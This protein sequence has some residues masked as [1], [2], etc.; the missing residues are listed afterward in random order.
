MKKSDSILI[1]ATIGLLAYV[2]FLSLLGPA[3]S[4]AQ[5]SKTIGNAG[6]VTAV[7]V[8]VYW[9]SDGTNPVSSFSWGMIDPGTNESITCYI[10]NEGNSAVTLSMSTSSWNPSNAT[11]YMTLSWN[12]GGATLTPGQIKA[13]TFT[14][15]VSASVHGIT[16]FSFN[17]II[18]GSG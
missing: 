5:M 1:I 14:L 16:S 8:G 10:K 3:M 7:G 4:S 18:V 9:N 17:I 15:A 11:Q 6:S 13:A 12:L 2:L